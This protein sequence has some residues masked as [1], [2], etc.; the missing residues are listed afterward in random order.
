VKIIFLPLKVCSQALT[1]VCNACLL[2]QFKKTEI[3][4]SQLQ[5]QINNLCFV[6]LHIY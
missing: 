3:K 5:I 1:S 2:V 6:P 4:G